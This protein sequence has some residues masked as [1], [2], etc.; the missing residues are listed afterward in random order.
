LFPTH[1]L[2][3][4]QR[5]QYDISRDGRL[6]LNSEVEETVTE[7]MHLPMNGKPPAKYGCAS[8]AIVSLFRSASGL[9]L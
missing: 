5:Q 9:C 4:A 1:V 7:P 6:L 3:A 2:N 8:E